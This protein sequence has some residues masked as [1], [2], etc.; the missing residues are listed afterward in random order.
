MIFRTEINPPVSDKK[1]EFNDSLLTLGSCFAEEIGR[2]MALHGFQ[3]S[4]N[5]LG[6]LYNPYSI[7]HLLEFI[8]KKSSV[9]QLPLVYHNGLW[10][11]YFHHGKF[12][13]PNKN[14]LLIQ[15][16]KIHSEVLQQLHEA[17]WI[18]FTLG[19][20]IVHV[21]KSKEMI[22]A[23]CHQVPANN[24]YRRFLNIDEL[25]QKFY[26][27]YKLLYQINPFVNILWTISPV[28]YAKYDLTHNQIS[29]SVLFTWLHHLLINNPAFYYFPSY[30]IMIDDLRDY[31]FYKEDL[32]HPNNMATDYIWEK[33]VATFISS[34]DNAI[35]QEFYDLWK[36]SLHK[37][38]HPETQQASDLRK[39]LNEKA[40]LLKNNYPGHWKYFQ[41]F[42]GE[43]IANL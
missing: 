12:S 41:N 24:F 29:K 5:P 43:N 17:R 23:N 39:K 27:F 40:R 20:A 34:K 16:E 30:E 31:R 2:K 18:I 36:L 11:S 21:E 1:I 38:L 19:S 6:T 25:N 33:F 42:L 4:I 26:S 14:Q 37:I 22:V 13:S 9:D 3:V 7:F 8:L 35:M 15:V 28:R 32:I 10:H